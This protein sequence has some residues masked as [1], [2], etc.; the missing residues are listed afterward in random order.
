MGWDRNRPI[1]WRRLLTEWAVFTVV[2]GAIFSVVIE[3]N[4]LTNL[5]ALAIGGGIYVLLGAALAKF[6]YQRATLRQLR[7]ESRAKAAAA[8]RGPGA[9]GRSATRRPT[10]TKRTNAS[11]RRR[12]R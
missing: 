5:I 1:P 6:G 7:A 9:P 12:S 10:P 4:R 11:Q 3:E 2:A 8:Q